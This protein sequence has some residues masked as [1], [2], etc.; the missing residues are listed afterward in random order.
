MRADLVVVEDPADEALHACV[1]GAM[2]T[3]RAVEFSGVTRTR[4][5]ELRRD[6]VLKVVRVGR[7]TLWPRRSLVELLARNLAG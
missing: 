5:F 7:Q 3:E 2:T 4:L 6:G 1:D